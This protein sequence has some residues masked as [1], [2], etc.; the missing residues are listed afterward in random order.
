MTT[1]VYTAAKTALL[2]AGLDLTSGLTCAAMNSSFVAND[3]NSTWSDISAN[4]LGTPVAATSASVTSG[5][6]TAKFP[7]F[8]DIPTGSVISALVMYNATTGVLVS[9]DTSALNLPFTADGSNV[10]ISYTNDLVLEID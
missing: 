8:T 7:D 5:K 9:Y 6:L 2:K 3:A 1:T 4:V 10:S